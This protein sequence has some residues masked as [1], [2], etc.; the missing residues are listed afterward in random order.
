MLFAERTI[1]WH[2]DESGPALGH[3]GNGV[4]AG[5]G[6]HDRPPSEKSLDVIDPS[7]NDHVRL[8]HSPCSSDVPREP[9]VARL[10]SVRQRSEVAR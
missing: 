9:E 8:V 5:A 4:V 10:R 6:H 7:A 1:L 3:V 2:H